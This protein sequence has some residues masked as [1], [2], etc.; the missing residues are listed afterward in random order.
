[1]PTTLFRQFISLKFLERNTGQSPIIIS[2]KLYKDKTIVYHQ[3]FDA[4]FSTFRAIPFGLGGL[5]LGGT[6]FL[7]TDMFQLE[8]L[9]SLAGVPFFIAL[10]F[11]PESPRWLL[12]NG[13]E[14]EG[15]LQ[16]VPLND[17]FI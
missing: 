10:F 5:A 6:L 1:M 8:L 12:V 14:E 2:G 3:A 11:L 7:V 4:Y 9:M 13:R 15:K 16:N 17:M